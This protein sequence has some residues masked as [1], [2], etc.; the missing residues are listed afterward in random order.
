MSLGDGDPDRATVS[1]AFFSLWKSTI[2]DI[3]LVDMV[4]AEDADMLGAVK[5][6][7]THVLVDSVGGAIVP[8]LA[9]PHLRR[10]WIDE[11][12]G[13]PVRFQPF[14]ICR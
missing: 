7:Q 9:H 13:D 3:H 1:A 12:A 5:L 4:A 11:A 10:N 14:F 6:R 8:T 2:T